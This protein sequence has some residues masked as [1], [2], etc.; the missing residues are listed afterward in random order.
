[1]TLVELRD[2]IDKIIQ[3]HPSWANVNRIGRVLSEKEDGYREMEM[4]EDF[5]RI[6]CDGQ[7]MVAFE[8][9]MQE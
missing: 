6:C 7:G 9:V 4:L 5:R 1:M 2:K 3:E 8:L